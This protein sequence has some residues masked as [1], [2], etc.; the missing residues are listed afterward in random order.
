M[1]SMFYTFYCDLFIYYS[2][3]G[4]KCRIYKYCVTL[5][6]IIHKHLPVEHGVRSQKEHKRSKVVKNKSLFTPELQMAQRGVPSLW[7]NQRFT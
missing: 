1:A 5:T 7:R 6:P 4:I 2:L 3:F